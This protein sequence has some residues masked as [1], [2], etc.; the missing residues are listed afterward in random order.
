MCEYIIITVNVMMRGGYKKIRGKILIVDTN[1]HVHM[2][3]DKI[4][5]CYIDIINKYTNVIDENGRN[6]KEATINTMLN[7]KNDMINKLLGSTPKISILRDLIYDYKLSKYKCVDDAKRN[8]RNAYSLSA[9][10]TIGF[11]L[12]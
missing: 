8:F 12:K 3:V 6:V 1:V 4:V 10:I 5:D 2:I 11:G 9:H 7:N